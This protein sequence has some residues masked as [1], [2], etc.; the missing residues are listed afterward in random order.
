MCAVT[1][2]CSFCI[3]CIAYKFMWQRKREICVW[4][5]V[6]SFF[7]FISNWSFSILKTF[8]HFCVHSAC[9]KY[10]LSVAASIQICDRLLCYRIYPDLS[11]MRCFVAGSIQVCDSCCSGTSCCCSCCSSG[12]QK[13]R[14]ERREWK[15]RW[16]HGIWSFWLNIYNFPYTM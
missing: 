15:W 6:S 16:W 1:L 8:Q 7:S 5:S 10:N 9:Y 14:E 3:C 13:G 11:Q 4:L 12:V 2:L